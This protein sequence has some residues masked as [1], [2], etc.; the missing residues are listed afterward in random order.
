MH[1]RATYRAGII[2]S[3]ITVNAPISPGGGAV[4]LIRNKKAT[5]CIAHYGPSGTEMQGRFKNRWGSSIP[6]VSFFTDLIHGWLWIE[7]IET[8]NSPDPEMVKPVWKY[9]GISLIAE[10][11]D[12][13]LVEWGKVSENY[14]RFLQS[15]SQSLDYPL[16][17]VPRQFCPSLYHN[18]LFSPTFLFFRN[19]HIETFKQ[20]KVSQ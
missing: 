18:F 9:V 15:R 8:N 19:K 17:L 20:V 13:D 2:V 4:K 5:P 6:R 10:E 11:W 14:F 1:L 7:C 3:I 16:C 12:G